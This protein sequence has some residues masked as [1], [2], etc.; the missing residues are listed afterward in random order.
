MKEVIFSRQNL[1]TMINNLTFPVSPASLVKSTIEYGAGAI[2]FGGI[3]YY[4]GGLTSASCAILS[5]Y[6]NDYKAGQISAFKA[7]YT[8]WLNSMNAGNFTAIKVRV[9]DPI[10]IYQA[11]GTI[12][13]SEDIMSIVG[14]KNSSGNWI[15]PS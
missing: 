9:S 6:I 11:G 2:M 14:F 13:F 3:G 4:V 8:S 5:E 7:T 15:L 1:Q 12:K 10:D